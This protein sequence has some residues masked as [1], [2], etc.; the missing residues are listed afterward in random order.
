M[1]F[2]SPLFAFGFGN[3][4]MLGWLA[5]AAAPIL[6][7]LWNKRRY[8]EVRWAAIEYLLAAMRQNSRRMRLEQWLLLAIR[9]L[10]VALVVIA[11]AQPFLDQL[12]LNFVPGE[13][14]LKVLVIDGSY[15][16]AY[17]PTD[18]SQFER[19]KQLAAQIVEDSSQGDAF[20]LVLMASPPSVIVGS[21]AVEPH[22]FLEEIRNLKLVHAGADLPATLVDV[23][24][25]LNST[26]DSGL[27]RKEVYFFTDLGRNSWAPDLTEGQAQEYRSRLAGLAQQASLVVVDLAGQSG[28]ENLAVT[29]L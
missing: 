28:A 20:T 12:G 26:A 24:R 9:T 25:I 7:H 22:D 10:L 1:I 14:T 27:S 3:I 29:S 4:L 2:L 13:R 16:M 15:S 5:A 17:K 6:I 18:K 19:A 11:V 8:R 23:E 21:P